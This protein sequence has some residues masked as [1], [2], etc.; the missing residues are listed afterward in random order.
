MRWPRRLLDR[1]PE[2]AHILDLGCGSALP[3]G[4]EVVRQHRLTGID[5]S[6]AQV[7]LARHN[8]PEAS[9]IHSEVASVDLPHG[10]FDAVVSFYAI[11]HIP[12]AEHAGLM[13]NIHAWLRPT[14]LLLIS[15]EAGDEPAVTAEWS[16][17]PMFFSHFDE[18]TTIA[19]VEAAGFD[20]IE[21]AVEA[22]EE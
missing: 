9:F 1:V 15:V 3:V 10:E 20:A 16:G 19:L 2:G 4:P 13:R 17:A 18:A 12:R 14:G 5:I 6:A 11:D 8:V 21:T 22:Q 7:E